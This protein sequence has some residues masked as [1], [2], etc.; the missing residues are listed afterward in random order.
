MRY[1]LKKYALELEQAFLKER[2]AYAEAANRQIEAES[3]RRSAEHF[4]ETFKGEKAA[5]IAYAEAA[6]VK[7]NA[8]FDNVSR[9][10]WANFQREKKRLT[11]ELQ[12]AVYAD[13]LVNPNRV[14]EVTLELLKSGVC[15]ADDYI[16][17]LNRF[18]GNSTMRRLIGKYA[19]DA[20]SSSEEVAERSKLE[21]AAR[22]ANEQSNNIMNSWNELCSMADTLT[23]QANGQA[24]RSYTLHMNEQW[25]QL[26][27]PVIAEL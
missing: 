26:V 8:E 19:S 10:C 3:K 27:A 11:E 18:D 5:K 22:T 16:S 7:A 15:G 23:G 2:K 1:T 4:E 24:E 6:L 9:E 12:Q 25:E 13:S 14:D 21:Y 20:A 17:L